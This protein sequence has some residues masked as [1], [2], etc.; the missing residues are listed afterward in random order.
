MR[1]P[2]PNS[3]PY[4]DIKIKRMGALERGYIKCLAREAKK[5]LSIEDGWDDLAS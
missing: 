3:A 2:T 4:R 5:Y 1:V